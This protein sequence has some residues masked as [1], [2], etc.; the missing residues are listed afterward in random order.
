MQCNGEE[1]ANQRARSEMWEWEWMVIRGINKEWSS[2]M[3]QK[4]KRTE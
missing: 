2:V 3:I 4:E 1:G